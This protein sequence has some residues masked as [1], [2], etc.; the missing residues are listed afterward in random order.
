LHWWH[1]EPGEG[2]EPNKSGG[3]CTHPKNQPTAH[4]GS[5]S[6]VVTDST[7][8][9]TRCTF[10]GAGVFGTPTNGPE[11]VAQHPA[12]DL[13]VVKTVTPRYTAH[14]GDTLTWTIEVSNP[15]DAETDNVTLQDDFVAG[16][17]RA[18]IVTTAGTC[19]QGENAKIACLLGPIAPGATVTVTVTA[20]ALISSVKQSPDGEFLLSENRAMATTDDPLHDQDDAGALI[21]PKC[22]STYEGKDAAGK[23]ATM[24]VKCGDEGNDEVK[25]N[26]KPEI[27]DGGGGADDIFG[28]GGNDFLFGG[29]GK[30]LVDCGKGK[31]VAI[32]GPARDRFKGCEN[33]TQ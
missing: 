12:P 24:T 16:F 27:I 25:G 18:Q 2:P 21:L 19:S 28:L 1:G 26:S 14:V 3:E 32:G 30:D 31:D 22:G 23:P 10:E 17:S 20:K 13:L 29:D 15:G 4:A 6:V 9:S 7:G 8:L 11:C 5:I 33:Q